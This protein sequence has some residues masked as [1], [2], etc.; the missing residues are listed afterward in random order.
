MIKI[1]EIGI[2][3]G[4]EGTMTIA[5]YYDEYNAEAFVHGYKTADPTARI[6]IDSV[7]SDFIKENQ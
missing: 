5:T 4:D 1:Y 3:M 2:D 7:T 6:F